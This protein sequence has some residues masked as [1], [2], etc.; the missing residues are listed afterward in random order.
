MLNLIQSRENGRGPASRLLWREREVR[1]GNSH[2]PRHYP[3]KET[4]SW[5]FQVR[6]CLRCDCFL[7]SYSPQHWLQK[8]RRLKC[9]VIVL[10]FHILH[11]VQVLETSAVV[12]AKILKSK[13]RKEGLGD[14]RNGSD[15]KQQGNSNQ[16]QRQV[17][18]LASIFFRLKHM[19]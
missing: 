15:A 8:E 4:R 10:L 7:F 9:G 13:D 1:R 18:S 14:N 2:F 11:P 12:F 6:I 17:L 16:A 3:Q 19:L 5:T